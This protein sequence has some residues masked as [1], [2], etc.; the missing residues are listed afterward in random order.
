M[1]LGPNIYEQG[2]Q[3]DIHTCRGNFIYICFE[4]ET[5]LNYFGKDVM[6]LGRVRTFTERIRY[7]G[8]L[9]GQSG[10]R[11]RVHTHFRKHGQAILQRPVMWVR[12]GSCCVVQGNVFGS[13]HLN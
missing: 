1:I 8:R 11:D 6:D 13:A 10:R 2:M 5:A 3:G 12:S 7:M 9:P 4:H